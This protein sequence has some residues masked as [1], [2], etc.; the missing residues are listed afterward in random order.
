M[1]KF[2]IAAFFCTA[3]L[4]LSVTSAFAVDCAPGTYP[5]T[6]TVNGPKP[7]CPCDAAQMQ[8]RHDDVKR[9]EGAAYDHQVT[10]QN[11][12]SIGMTCFDHALKLTSKLGLIFSDI[13][14]TGIFPAANTRVFG[15]DYDDAF[16]TGINPNNNKVKTLANALDHV[17]TDMM[18]A[19]AENF[20]DSLS[21][22]LGATDLEF[23]SAFMDPI[24]ALVQAILAPLAAIQAAI[25]AIQTIM[26]TLLTTLDLLNSMFPSLAPTWINT[27]ITP[28][29]KQIKTT[30]LTAVQKVQQTIIT[31]ITDALKTL[32]TGA[33]IHPHG[34]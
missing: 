15:T 6:T 30:L 27:V 23:M 34:R 22:M 28:I 20:N 1:K 19:V 9:V 32:M 29:W 11:D 33:E 8:E 21:N 25:N 5:S 10:K 31:T 17:I 7:G 3:L 4:G 14:T 18:Q 26:N 12:N 16:G 2:L 24:N 13:P